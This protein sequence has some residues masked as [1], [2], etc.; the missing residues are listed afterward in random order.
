[1]NH[2]QA[3]QRIDALTTQLEEHSHNYHVLASPTI[4]DGEFDRLLE[5][6]VRLEGEWPDL[7]RPESPT[8]RVGGAPTSDFPTVAHAT[9]MLSLDNSYSRED[10]V[11]FDARVHNGLDETATVEYVAELKIDGVALS[12][13][14]EDSRLVRAVT[15]G[16][17][18][19]GD[20]VTNNARTIRSVPLRLRE[21]G[22]T[23]EVRG[24][25]YMAREDF[26]AL[27]RSQQEA[28][29]PMF[30]NPRNSTAGT[31]KLQ[32]PQAVARRRLRCFTYWIDRAGF[33]YATHA[34][35]LESLRHLGFPVNPEWAHCPSLAEVFAFYGRC[36]AARDDLPYEVDGVVIKVD[37]LAQQEQLGFTA[38]SPRSAMAYKFRAEQVRSRLLEIRLQ[39]G[40][41]GTISPVAILEPVR[42]AGSTVQRATLHNADEIARKDIRVGDLVLLEK[43]GDVIPKV[44]GIVAAERPAG[45]EAFRFP[46]SCP[47]CDAA[48]VSYAD[49]VARRCVNPA[50]QGQL[51]RRIEHFCGRN[52][53]DI[54]GLGTA[55]VEQIVDRGL[56]HDIGDLYSLNAADFAELERLGEKSAGNLVDALTASRQRP[57][58]RV[59]F[60]IGI[61][62]VGATVARNLAR[63]FLSIDRLAAATAEDLAEVD[64]IGPVIAQS[65]R[66]FFA[67]PA[68]AP[69]LGKLRAAGLQLSRQAP[70]DAA[71]DSTQATFFT[72]KT[73]VLT[74]SMSRYSREEAGAIVERLGGR[75][76][77]SVSR[78]TDLLIAGDKAGS[79]LTKA[80]AL[81]V[82]VLGEEEFL[83][84]LGKLGI[85]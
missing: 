31:L 65:V 36:E 63:S 58:E 81:G 34:A 6:L 32:N 67:A 14:Y 55:V 54:E 84:E 12:L 79:K 37:S 26:A 23:C 50:C 48:L 21:P 17:G 83:L 35:R 10:V 66:D 59:L 41:T 20:E 22:I 4:A 16:D 5:E 27:N 43:G 60:G 1:M 42:V 30:A 82:R 53:M 49:E 71:D 19:Q 75:T 29:R 62:H 85:S 56:V 61:L 76:S 52:A 9:P 18:A 74:G 80:E 13:I 57:F 78:K 15:R 11:A 3:Q 38:K 73:V 47:V 39:V 72:G 44:V 70:E 2:D 68:T 51:K 45:T 33:A 8:Q 24:E 28:G 25:V 46:D 69:V 40:R 7:V 77:S 64:E